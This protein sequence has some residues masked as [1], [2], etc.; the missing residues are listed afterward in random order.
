MKKIRIMMNITI[1]ED[2]CPLSIVDSIKIRKAKSIEK[3]LRKYLKKEEPRF[4]ELFSVAELLDE[5]PFLTEEEAELLN[6]DR[7]K[8]FREQDPLSYTEWC[9]L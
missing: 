7:K 2:K 5:N 4:E 9:I 3:E 6:Q 1:D 8:R